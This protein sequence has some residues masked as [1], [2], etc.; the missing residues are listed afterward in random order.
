MT[1]MEIYQDGIRC[2]A[3]LANAKAELADTAKSLLNAVELAV[4]YQHERDAARATIAR[5]EALC[6]YA[7]DYEPIDFVEAVS[8]ALTEPELKRWTVPAPATSNS[9]L[10]VAALAEPVE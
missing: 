9:E 7:A 3:A 4:K 8:I 10:A 6:K 2:H 1:H 5:V